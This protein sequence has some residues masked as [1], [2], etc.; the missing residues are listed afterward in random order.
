MG[1]GGV[2]GGG[3][4]VRGGAFSS[5]SVWTRLFFIHS[6]IIFLYADRDSQL[7]ASS[8][9][10][11]HSAHARHLKLLP[12]IFRRALLDFNLLLFSS[13]SSRLTSSSSIFSPMYCGFLILTTF[14]A[15]VRVKYSVISLPVIHPVIDSSFFEDVLLPR[16]VTPS[17]STI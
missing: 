4:G 5:S 14:H 9:V 8:L 1:G 3:V 6:L 2:G 17:R 13:S 11:F 16:P 7:L 15:S 12:V 10:E